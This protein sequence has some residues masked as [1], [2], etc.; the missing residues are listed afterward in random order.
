MRSIAASAFA[1]AL[2]AIAAASQACDN[3]PAATSTWVTSCTNLTSGGGAA[4]WQGG[5]PNVNSTIVFPAGTNATV[6]SWNNATY[7]VPYATLA[8]A[9]III[10]PGAQVTMNGDGIQVTGCFAVRGSLILSSRSYRGVQW[11]QAPTTEYLADPQQP[12]GTDCK[13]VP[14]GFTPRICGPGKISVTGSVQLHGLYSSLFLGGEIAATGSL[15]LGNEVF[16]WGNLTN[17]GIM[18]PPGNDAV[19]NY[20]HGFVYNYGNAT[21]ATV[22]FDKWATSFVSNTANPL[23]IENHGFLRFGGSATYPTIVITGQTWDTYRVAVVNYA[24]VH[25]D[26]FVAPTGFDVYNMG[27]A[28]WNGWV[29]TGEGTYFNRGVF[30]ANSANVYLASYLDEGGTM[31][32]LGNGYFGFSNGSPNEASRATMQL[33]EL[34]T[35]MPSS[36]HETYLANKHRRELATRHI[37]HNEGNAV[38]VSGGC[39]WYA[40]CCY[41]EPYTIPPPQLRLS[42]ADEGLM[43]PLPID[44]SGIP[45][46]RHGGDV[47]LRIQ[48]I[49]ANDVVPTE[50]CRAQYRFINTTI[51]GDGSGSIVSTVPIQVGGTVKVA[52]GGRW[53]FANEHGSAPVY[54]GGTVEVRRGGSVFAGIDSDFHF[55]G[56]MIVQRGGVFAVPRHAKVAFS[57][58]TL[59]VLPGAKLHVDGQLNFVQRAHARIR[60]DN[61]GVVDGI[62]QVNVDREGRLACSKDRKLKRQARKPSD[63][64]TGTGS[65]VHDQHNSPTA[66]PPDRR[67][68]RV[69]RSS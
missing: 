36:L 8:A 68:P 42:A 41:T 39:W 37:A 13:T 15:V 59:R 18:G 53:Y 7:A 16:F 28:Q 12:L 9:N 50:P 46:I 32:T 67:R 58:H 51:K 33:C 52:N 62:G 20:Q 60:V 38:T 25:F 45:T 30:I 24:T 34:V 55:G 17:R 63:P 21:F 56:E 22:A 27:T 69:R 48:H 31:I 64:R 44:A 35:N 61:C 49:L 26:D 5:L 54:G 2:L 3:I 19:Y 29:Y 57:N 10:E 47:K 4:C 14:I 1:V 66:T 6:G 40:G 65:R 11:S 23:L 43:K